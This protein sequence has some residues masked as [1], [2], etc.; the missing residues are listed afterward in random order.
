MNH[1]WRQGIF[2]TSLIALFVLAI[3]LLSSI[4]HYAFNIAWIT[5]GPRMMLVTGLKSTSGL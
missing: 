4:N 1:A 5:S 2:W 3:H